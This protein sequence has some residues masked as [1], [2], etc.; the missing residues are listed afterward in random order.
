[1][2]VPTPTIMTIAG[3]DP[4]GGAGIQ[5]DLRVFGA[6]RAS[7][8]SAITGTTVQNSL[9]VRS[10]YPIP[11]DNLYRQIEAV[12]E[13]IDVAAVKIGMLCSVDQVR[14]VADALRRFRPANVVLDPVLAS[15]GGYPLLDAAG[16][17]V[18]LTDLLPLCDLVTPNIPELQTITGMPIGDERERTLAAKML[19]DR[20]AKAVLIKGG[21]L[22]GAPID[23]LTSQSVTELKSAEDCW[24]KFVSERVA[25][26]HTHGTGC[27][28]SSAI[29]CYLGYGLTLEMSIQKA[30]T[31]LTRALR[32][33]TIVGCGRGYPDVMKAVRLAVKDE[34]SVSSVKHEARRNLLRG[35]LYVI[36]D[37]GLRPDRKIEDIV[38]EALAGGA[39]VVQ[40]REKALGSTQLIALAKR[41]VELCRRHNAMLIVNDRVDVAAA[42]ADGVHLGPDD[43]SPIDARRVLGPDCLIGVSTGTVAEAIAC[44]PFASYLGVGAIFGSKTKSDAGA[45]IGP[46]RI[47]EIRDALTDKTIPLVAIG[48]ITADNISM[49]V[50]AGADSA[51]VVSA[52]IGAPNMRAATENLLANLRKT[53]QPS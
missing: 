44:A 37:S 16:L 21:H 24:T 46:D 50:R 10:V 23:V 17:A 32:T 51:A 5:A 34:D 40:L 36:T 6:L 19:L 25:T 12:L 1:M 29:A 47:T 8:L 28:L 2:I 45:A 9:G 52:V 42:D 18:L 39:R 38:Q 20:G 26:E 22:P 53:A 7:G 33:P 35:S 13:D 31:L 48:G 49:V 15:T 43:M 11:A 41:L 4:S 14:S 27:L 30:K 3:S